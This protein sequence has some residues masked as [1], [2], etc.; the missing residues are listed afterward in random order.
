MLLLGQ[1]Q[2]VVVGDE[3]QLP[4]TSFFSKADDT[5]EDDLD[6]DVN[7][8]IL[9]LAMTKYRNPRMLCSGTTGQIMKI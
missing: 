2:M 6:I 3:N 1:S 8:S 9:D 7:E 5:Q 4:P